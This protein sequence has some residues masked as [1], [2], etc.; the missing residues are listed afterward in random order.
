MFHLV[1]R[2]PKQRLYI[3]NIITFVTCRYLF[4]FIFAV[5]VNPNLINGGLSKP[6]KTILGKIWRHCDVN[7][8]NPL[9]KA[10]LYQERSDAF[11]KAIRGLEA[12]RLLKTCTC[13]YTYWGGQALTSLYKLKSQGGGPSPLQPPLALPL[14]ECATGMGWF[15]TSLYG[16]FLLEGIVM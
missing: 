1:F 7:I 5:Q 11:D 12:H 15:Y 14:V 8:F 6:F 9:R 16:C 3:A 4:L 13:A 10:V 2:G